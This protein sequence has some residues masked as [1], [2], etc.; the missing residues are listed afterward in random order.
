LLGI[1]LKVRLDACHQPTTC[2]YQYSDILLWQQHF[3]MHETDLVVTQYCNSCSPK[4]DH[5]CPTQTS[6]YVSTSMT[7]TRLLFRKLFMFPL[8]MKGM[9][10][11]GQE[12][13]VSKHTPRRP[14][15]WA[16]LKSFITRLSAKKAFTSSSVRRSVCLNVCV[17]MCMHVYVYSVCCVLVRVYVCACVCCVCSSYNFCCKITKFVI[18]SYSVFNCYVSVFQFH[19]SLQ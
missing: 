2:R 18:L 8:A 13:G 7:W 6:G 10:I 14:R 17:C 19:L 9:T 5:A 15:T 1:E 12:S 16:W 11:Y 4:V 3:E